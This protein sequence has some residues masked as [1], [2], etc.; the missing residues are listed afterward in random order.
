M[1]LPRADHEGF[2]WG[3]V[4]RRKG[5]RLAK[6]GRPQPL[7]VPEPLRAILR[8]WWEHEGRKVT[9]PVFPKRKGKGAGEQAR[10][11]GSH[12]EPFRRD[13]ARAFGLERPVVRDTMRSNGRKLR[14]IGWE[15]AREPTT[16]ERMLLEGSDLYLPVDFHSWRRAFNQALAD[17]GVNAQQA[18]ALSAHASMKAH[19]R[20]LRNTQQGPRGAFGG[21]AEDWAHAFGHFER[22]AA[23]TDG[24][25]TRER[26]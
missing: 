26:S 6:G 11:K 2:E 19:E 1:P 20:Y 10:A 25:G 13:L 21:A 24:S 7:Y 17:A 18:M 22:T 15:P 9:G 12:A 16:R 8:D 5:H 3:V 23:E 14:K 4:P